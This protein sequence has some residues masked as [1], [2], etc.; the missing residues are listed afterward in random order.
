MA[1][2]DFVKSTL[3]QM[4]GNSSGSET[5][6]IFLKVEIGGQET[7]ESSHKTLCFV[8][9]RVSSGDL[10]KHIARRV[11]KTRSHRKS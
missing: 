2:G 4:S 9:W 7:T 3:I 6:Q 8:I 5:H 10:K 1:G 11:H